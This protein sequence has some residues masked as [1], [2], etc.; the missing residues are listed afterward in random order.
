MTDD[1][2]ALA[3]IERHLENLARI[4]IKQYE[5]TAEAAVRAERDSDLKTGSD[6]LDKLA[7]A[8][9][10]ASFWGESLVA[11]VVTFVA[12]AAERFIPDPFVNWVRGLMTQFGPNQEITPPEARRYGVVAIGILAFAVG[13]AVY[14][15][16]GRG[17]GRR[18]KRVIQ[19]FEKVYELFRS[20]SGLN[21]YLQSGRHHRVQAEARI[22]PFGGMTWAQVGAVG[23][24][25]LVREQLDLLAEIDARRSIE[26]AEY[27][28]HG[29]EFYLELLRG[30]VRGEIPLVVCLYVAAWVSSY[31]P[32]RREWLGEA[33]RLGRAEAEVFGWTDRKDNAYADL[34]DVL[35]GCSWGWWR[36]AGQRLRKLCRLKL[37]DG[38]HPE[39][40]PAN[41]NDML[42]AWR[43]YY[44]L[45]MLRDAHQHEQ[46]RKCVDAIAV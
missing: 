37:R 44:P 9:E 35:D 16:R 24:G 14:W 17:R 7:N 2:P 46:F 8:K 23:K 4:Q 38:P 36:R 10:D 11:L 1:T 20:H 25:Q 5:E 42:A 41:L 22:H 32:G 26:A 30:G 29:G 21:S 33:R 31:A 12:W 19:A 27:D 40:N 15:L 18:R 34:R 6:R 28:R 43:K 45:P 39:F 13:F 3:H